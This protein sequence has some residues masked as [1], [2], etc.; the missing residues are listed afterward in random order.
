[1]VAEGRSLS[2]TIEIAQSL[3]RKIVESCREHGDP[4]P[5][6]FRDGNVA[7]REFRVRVMM[8]LWG[9]YQDFAS[10][11]LQ[12]ASARSVSASTAQAQAVMKYG[13]I[14]EQAERLQFLIM[15]A[16]WREDR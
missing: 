3:A 6:A 2:E 12:D 10:A 4:L 9:A 7:A 8:T 13:V 5:P 16:I 11:K 14:R 1:M 15:G